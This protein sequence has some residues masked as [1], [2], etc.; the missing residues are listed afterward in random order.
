MAHKRSS[1][2]RMGSL[3]TLKAVPITDPAEQARINR[4]FDESET[5]D[6][7]TGRLIETKP[8]AAKV[9]KLCRQL[10]APK[11]LAAI[12]QMAAELS[13]TAQRKLIEQLLSQLPPDAL[14]K[15]EARISKRNGK[16]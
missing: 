1:T 12:T 7:Y 15:I 9:A 13:P 8:T 14:G 5:V 2:P 10:A 4:L 3:Q 6:I 16:R 11:R